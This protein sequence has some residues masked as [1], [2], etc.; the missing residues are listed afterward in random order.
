MPFARK[1]RQ[2]FSAIGNQLQDDPPSGTAPLL[3][4]ELLGIFNRTESD[5]GKSKVLERLVEKRKKNQLT[6]WCKDPQALEAVLK[7]HKRP[8]ETSDPDYR[9]KAQKYT[10]SQFDHGL[11]SALICAMALTESG[12]KPQ[13]APAWLRHA[14]QAIAL[15]NYETDMHAPNSSGPVHKQDLTIRGKDEKRLSFDFY[16]DPISFMLRLADKIHMWERSVHGEVELVTESDWAQLSG[17]VW[18]LGDAPTWVHTPRLRLF[19]EDEEAL[20]LTD[21]DHKHVSSDLRKYLAELPFPSEWGW[22]DA[23]PGDHTFLSYQITLPEVD[24]G[25]VRA[26]DR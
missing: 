12:L 9:E 19:Y 1:T 11:V 5:Q 13:D 4:D 8:T 15:H 3:A 20:A 22:A 23:P 21:W 16:R 17:L 10:R 14:V 26:K 2:I 7:K 6:E 18:K 25:I 24:P